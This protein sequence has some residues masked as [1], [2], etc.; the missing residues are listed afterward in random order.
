MASQSYET[1]S[2][3]LDA[4]GLSQVLPAFR[5]EASSHASYR[6]LQ[7]S[8]ASQEL[9]DSTLDDVEIRDLKQVGLSEV[10]ASAFLAEYRLQTNSAGCSAPSTPVQ[11]PQLCAISS[12]DTG[13]DPDAILPPNLMQQPLAPKRVPPPLPPPRKASVDV[14]SGPIAAPSGCMSITVKFSVVRQSANMRT[15][16]FSLLMFRHN[17]F[18]HTFSISFN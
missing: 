3:L 7:N 11:T 9:D 8:C 4:L 13:A 18:F 2:S 6:C 10:Q 5:Q 17:V 12:P 16:H 1:V 14:A 15:S